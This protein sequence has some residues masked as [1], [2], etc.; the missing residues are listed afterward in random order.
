MSV[1]PFM[2]VDAYT[3]CPL[4]GNPCAVLFDTDEM[5]SETMLAVARKMK[6]SETAFVCKS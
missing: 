3:D 2:Q 1:Y 4:S 5:D 6:L